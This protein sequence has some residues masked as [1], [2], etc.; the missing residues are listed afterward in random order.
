MTGSL[1][2]PPPGSVGPI[3]EDDL[4]LEAACA[5][6]R[7]QFAP[8]DFVVAI[9]ARGVERTVPRRRP[10]RRVGAQLAHYGCAYEGRPA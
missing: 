1:L 4:V 8:G 10:Q 2:E 6:C 9:P 5:L 3:P 7:R